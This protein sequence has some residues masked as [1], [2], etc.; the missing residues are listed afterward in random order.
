MDDT[1]QKARIDEV[2]RKAKEEVDRNTLA[3]RQLL[4]DQESEQI[5]ID[6]EAEIAR[7]QNDAQK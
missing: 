1:Q 4:A 3:A 6:S 7:I 5:R 2:A